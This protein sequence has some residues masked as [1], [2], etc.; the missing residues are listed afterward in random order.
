MSLNFE[1]QSEGDVLPIEKAY[2][3]YV[4]QNPETTLYFG[5]IGKSFPTDLK[6]FMAA[7]TNVEI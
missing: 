7:L 3:C 5:K 1:G 2:G 6:A 4:S